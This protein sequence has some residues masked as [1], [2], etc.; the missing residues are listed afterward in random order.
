M[1]SAVLDRIKE[2]RPGIKSVCFSFVTNCYDNIVIRDNLAN[3][4]ISNGHRSNSKLNFVKA[5]LKDVRGRAV[6]RKH[7]P[8]YPLRRLYNKQNNP[9]TKQL[10]L[11]SLFPKDISRTC[12]K[13]TAATWQRNSI[14]RVLFETAEK[15]FMETGCKKQV[16]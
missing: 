3:P 8:R 16:R 11:F 9:R 4:S 15:R 2:K 5:V 6:Q 7:D 1:F 14:L 13:I 12:G 10:F